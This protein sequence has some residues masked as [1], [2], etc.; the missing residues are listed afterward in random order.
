MALTYSDAKRI[1]IIDY[2]AGLGFEPD[3]VRGNDYWYR[4]PLRDENNPSFKVNSKLNVWFDHG[5]GTGGSIL[6]LGI[7]LHQCSIHEFL[8]MLSNGNFHVDRPFETKNEET[9]EPK[10]KVLSVKRITRSPLIDY[11]VQRSIDPDLARLYCK[12]VEFTLAN[13]TYCAVGFENQSGG[14]ELRNS[15]FKGSSSPKDISIVSNVSP[16]VCILE[17]FFDFL[18]L[19]QINN[20]EVKSLIKDSDFL[21]LN[22]LSFLHKSLPI[23]KNYSDKITFMDNDTAGRK[24]IDIL[25]EHGIFFKDPSTLYATYKDLNEFLR[26]EP[27]NHK[28]SKKSRGFKLRP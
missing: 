10:I 13:K 11:L 28:T 15:W 8:G 17:G 18:S 16:K 22:S 7:K 12:E 1:A 20:D 14:Y 25:T 19:H 26:G 27:S 21:V 24:A 2:L 3:K 23:I 6:D 9:S 5:I 4:S